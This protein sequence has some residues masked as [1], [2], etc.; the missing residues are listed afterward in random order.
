MPSTGCRVS[1]GTASGWRSLVLENDA[2]RVVVLPDKGAD[3][4]ELMHVDTG[5]DVLFKGPWGLQAPGAPPLEGSGEDEFMWNYEGGWQEL[6]PSVNAACTYRGNRIPFHGEVAS[7]PWEYDIVEDEGDEATVRLWTRCRQTPFRLERVMR[8]RRGEPELTLEGTVV[9][10]SDEPA[11]L[12]WGQHCVLGPPFLEPGCRLEVPARTIVTPPVLWESET[13]RLA[14][15]QREPWPHARLR[16]GGTVDLSEVPGPEAE[17]HDDLFVTDLE[18]G[19]LSVRKPYPA[20]TFRLEW[21]SAVFG[22]VVL[23]QPYGGARAKPLSGSY[24]LGVEPW[25]SRLTLEEAVAAGEAIELAGG[26]RLETT[27]RARLERG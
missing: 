8:L 2:L 23:W 25:T 18:A 19:W 16:S 7:L 13:A 22:W 5:I 4:Y 24:A 1:T 26:G 12:V 11:H 3:I 10:E 21:D 27:I 15:G 9:N 14:P 17:S 6:L 20:L